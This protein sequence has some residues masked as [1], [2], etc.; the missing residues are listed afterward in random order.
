ML[1]PVIPI[2]IIF[3][4]GFLVRK[5]LPVDV[6][7]CSRLAVI[8]FIPFLVFRSF[9]SN[10]LSL[11]SLYYA[12]YLSGT[13]GGCLLIVYFVARLRNRSATQTCGMMLASAFSNNG[14]YG[15][16][17][18][19]FAFGNEAGTVAITLMVLQQL[20]MHTLG[21]SIAAAGSTV[22]SEGK[23]RRI[24]LWRM[25]ILYGAVGGLVFH[26]LSWPIHASVWQVIQSL[27]DA[28]VPFMM[29]VLGMQLG[30]MT[31]GK[32]EWRRLFASVTIKLLAAPLLA[33]LIVAV[34]PLP[35]L[36]KQV[37]IVL[38]ATPTAV[39][40]T[41]YAV[42]YDTDASHVSAATLFS[43]LISLATVPV[44]LMLVS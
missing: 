38:A 31:L 28:A 29:V 35:L 13:V 39:N 8:V 16:P 11:T 23:R 3:F 32:L 12:L 10:G 15:I 6:S 26:W 37:M 2:F 17:L 1:A 14:N 18:V 4:I 20:L 33:A 22:L 44:V 21:V 19:L 36:E 25:P 41:L 7:M 24:K 34:L 27:A 40:T 5:R 42:Q 43:T 9:Y 30:A